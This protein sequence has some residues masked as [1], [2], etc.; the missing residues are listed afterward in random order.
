MYLLEPFGCT[1]SATGACRG[2]TSTL[3]PVPAPLPALHPPLSSESAR[4][5]TNGRVAGSDFHPRASSSTAAPRTSLCLSRP[6]RGL[7]PFLIGRGRRRTACHGENVR[8]EIV[9][10]ES[11]IGSG[12]DVPPAVREVSDAPTGCLRLAGFSNRIS[13]IGIPRDADHCSGVMRSTFLAEADHDSKLMPIAFGGS[14][15]GDRHPRSGFG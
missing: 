9:F 11:L 4:S 10:S 12:Q 3:A 15:N 7:S 13:S 8:N 1:P 5:F 6:N 2:P 14:G